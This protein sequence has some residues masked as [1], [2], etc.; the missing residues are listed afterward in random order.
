MEGWEKEWRGGEGHKEGRG[1][2]MP[3]RGERRRRRRKK[4]DERMKTPE[5][6]TRSPEKQTGTLGTVVEEEEGGKTPRPSKKWDLK[7][8]YG[9]GGGDDSAVMTDDESETEE[10]RPKQVKIRTFSKPI[11]PFLRRASGVGGKETTE[12]HVAFTSHHPQRRRTSS[13]GDNDA[14]KPTQERDEE[15]EESEEE[16]EE[17][18]EEYYGS[19]PASLVTHYE[20]RIAEIQHGIDALDIEGLK[21]KVLCKPPSLF[22]PVGSLGL[23]NLHLTSR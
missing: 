5:K 15:E 18:E 23:P 16:E 19:L 1:F 21:G 7:G 22:A 11:A 13:V 14:P 20:R 4:G 2:V 8:D 17:E 3:E 9:F 10:S 12:E 6:R